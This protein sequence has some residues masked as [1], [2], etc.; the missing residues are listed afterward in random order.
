MSTRFYCNSPPCMHAGQGPFILEFSQEAVLDRNNLAAVF[1]HRCG[2]PM[3]QLAPDPKPG[4]CGHRFYCH[5]NACSNNE[6]GL[7]FI[8]LPGEAILD[9]NNIA[10]IFC[11]KCGQEMRAFGQEPCVAINF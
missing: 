3:K 5:N 7:F 9:K 11:P 2:S 8:D 4:H 10:T 6:N 1:C